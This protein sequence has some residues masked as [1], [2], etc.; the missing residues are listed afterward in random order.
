MH[1][2]TTEDD[3]KGNG[4]KDEGNSLTALIDNL[5]EKVTDTAPPYSA[6][7]TVISSGFH[8]STVGDYE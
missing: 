1:D 7:L 3:L 5:K 2:G 4:K 6:G 8:G